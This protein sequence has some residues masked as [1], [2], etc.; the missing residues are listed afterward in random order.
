M[1]AEFQQH[2]FA[3]FAAHDREP[4][5]GLLRPVAA[6]DQCSRHVSALAGD[7][8]PAEVRREEDRGKRE[9]VLLIPFVGDDRGGRRARVEREHD[10]RIHRRRFVRAFQDHVE[11]VCERADLPGEILAG[12]YDATLAECGCGVLQ[13]GALAAGGDAEMD[14][15]AQKIHFCA[16]SSLG[17]PA[18]F[19][20]R[21]GSFRCAQPQGE[22][23]LC[24]GGSR[25]DRP[26][27][28]ISQLARR[29][30]LALRSLRAPEIAR[31]LRI[32]FVAGIPRQRLKPGFRHQR[33]GIL[34]DCGK[35]ISGGAV[36]GERDDVEPAV[37]PGR[38]DPDVRAA[39]LDRFERDIFRRRQIRRQRDQL[40]ALAIRDKIIHPAANPCRPVAGAS[41][42]IGKCQCAI[43]A[44]EPGG[45]PDRLLAVLIV[46][47]KINPSLGACPEG[48]QRGRSLPGRGQGDVVPVVQP[49]AVKLQILPDARIEIQIIDTPACPRP[50][51]R[52]LVAGALEVH[53]K[54]LV[55]PCQPGVLFFKPAVC[56][57]DIHPASRPRRVAPE[58]H[59]GQLLR[60]ERRVNCIGLHRA[61]SRVDVPGVGVEI[62]VVH[63]PVQGR[64]AGQQADRDQREMLLVHNFVLGKTRENRKRGRM[65]MNHSPPHQFPKRK[66]L[67]LVAAAADGRERYEP[68]QREQAVGG[69]LRHGVGKEVTR[70]QAA[71]IHRKG[72]VNRS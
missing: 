2:R 14:R 1:L 33:L 13:A 7:H 46:V 34:H 41:R 71:A 39:R 26:R 64:P 4:D 22:R 16:I 54:R 23:R 29:D 53:G 48:R 12:I 19:L 31:K 56:P 15:R 66:P 45:L 70:N 67:R 18:Q 24:C 38:I 68:A 20:N 59:P 72:I 49:G 61:I 17:I 8:K 32:S 6:A 5:I 35:G 9:A 52:P 57:D 60:L 65:A 58:R 25:Q 40:E 30:P 36:A 43:L 28:P 62:N 63:R 47:E 42:A 21:R 3:G 10:L 11:S 44:G 55:F 27:L 51:E 69:R 37:L 50:P